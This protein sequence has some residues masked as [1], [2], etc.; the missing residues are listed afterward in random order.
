M[1]MG[2]RAL[3]FLGMSV[4]LAACGEEMPATSPATSSAPASAPVAAPTKVSATISPEKPTAADCL[5]LMVKGQPGNSRISWQIN[6]QPIKASEPGKLCGAFKR[7]DQVSVTV[8]TAEAGG[9]ATVTIGNTPPK[10]VNITANPKEWYGGTKMEVFP[11]AEDADGDPVEFRYQ[12]LINDEADPFLTSSV[13][14]AERNRRGDRVQ[15]LIT[16][17]DGTSE[18]PVYSSYAMPVPGAP[19]KIVSKPPASFEAY[20]YSYQVRVKDPDNDKLVFSLDNPPK[21]MTIGKRSGKITWP[22]TGVQAGNYDVKIVVR[23]PEG[24]EDRQEYVLTLGT[25]KDQ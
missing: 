12:W 21:G 18:G 2:I 25:P 4:V 17:F 6:G 9:T 8:G 20:E 23:D 22:L 19:P 24:G 11:V 5:Q 13:P 10:V 14:P 3:F 16:P 1:N 15:V 7:G